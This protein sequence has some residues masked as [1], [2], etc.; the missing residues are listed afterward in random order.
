M[1]I[2]KEIITENMNAPRNLEIL[3]Q[4]NKKGFAEIIKSMYEEES[5]LIIEYWY[6]RL[7]YKS[8]DK[9]DNAKK[10]VFTAFLIIFSW[11]PIRLMF[12]D[13]F[14]D[15]NYLIKSIPVMFSIT[16]SLFFLFGSINVKNIVLGILPSIVIYIYSV[17]L[18]NNHLSQSLS[19]AF[20]FSF[21]LLWFFIL[22]A[23]SNCNIKKLQ[24]TVFIEKTGET[25]IWSTMFIIGG[26]IIVGLSLA[27]FNAIKI[28]ADDFYYE[29]I[30]TLGLAASPFVSLLVIESIN[31]VKLSVIIANI[32]LPL[33]FVSLIVFGTISVFT[34]TKPY[35]DRDIFIVYNIMM[36]I[37][38]C[39]LI[40]TSINGIHNKIINICS[41]FLPII[42]IILD[43]VTISAVIYRLN[44]YGITANKI[45]LLGT[46]ITM[47]GHLLYMVYLKT[48][49]KIELNMA[50]L[51]VYFFWAFCVVFV[52]PF[53]FRMA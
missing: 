17:L 7:F 11:I 38:I 51:P 22:F 36:V 5:N 12:A 40:F 4:S 27:L 30:M 50:Y 10:Y 2:T 35:E 49:H 42:T 13:F 23:E 48:K 46:N 18:P 8:L 43:V 34:E 1:E 9:K 16:L 53:I 31:R 24:F 47:L 45:T 6:V 21:V 3:Y 52:L 15:N 44:K 25:I 37:V 32:F 41:C 39:V 28:N 33:I 26:G 14:H 20:Y 19:N 29:N